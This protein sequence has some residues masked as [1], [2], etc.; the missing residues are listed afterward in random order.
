[1]GASPI[2][3]RTF[4]ICFFV[5]VRCWQ[6]CSQDRSIHRIRKET[7]HS[8]PSP[9]SVHQKPIITHPGQLQSSPT[10]IFH[11][12]PKKH[13]AHPDSPYQSITKSR[14]Y[15]QIHLQQLMMTPQGKYFNHGR[16]DIISGPQENKMQVN[17]FACL[18]GKYHSAYSP[19]ALNELN[20]VLSQ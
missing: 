3:E 13:T 10:R 6:R 18:T 14:Q 20:L 4:L 8:A 16:R 1:M 11:P 2:Q 7:H 15:T 9:V 19:Y 5:S 12:G 17:F